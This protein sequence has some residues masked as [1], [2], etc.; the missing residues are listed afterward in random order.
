[1]VAAFEW[2]VH[3]WVDV[4]SRLERSSTDPPIW[5]GRPTAP[6]LPARSRAFEP[7]ASGMAMEEIVGAAEPGRVGQGRHISQER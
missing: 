7:S 4:V 3:G 6:E 5:H 1:V 2:A